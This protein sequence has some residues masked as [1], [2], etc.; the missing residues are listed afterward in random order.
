MTDVI[1]MQQGGGE[2]SREPMDELARTSRQT[3]EKPNFRTEERQVTISLMGPQFAA[4]ARAARAS[5]KGLTPARS[6]G[7][8]SDGTSL[9]SDFGRC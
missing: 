9:A 8:A 4:A 5:Q 7:L 2:G 3:Q 1:P 6:V